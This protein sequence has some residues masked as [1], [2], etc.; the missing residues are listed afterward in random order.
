MKKEKFLKLA[1]KVWPYVA[2]YYTAQVGLV[3]FKAGE[4]LPS[5]F[6]A[7]DALG[8]TVIF[9][10]LLFAGHLL[11]ENSRERN[12]KKTIDNMSEKEIKEELQQEIKKMK[13]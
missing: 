4:L 10:A 3:A 8:P 12:L 9:T 13:M 2:G 5:Q 7:A 1:D 6:V 11:L